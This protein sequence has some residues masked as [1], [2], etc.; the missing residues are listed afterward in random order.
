MY[1][2]KFYKRYY[3]AV[4]QEKDF[5]NRDCRRKRQRLINRAWHKQQRLLTQSRNQL[6][7]FSNYKEGTNV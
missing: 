2:S 6:L 3:G 7:S 1:K 5:S 4:N